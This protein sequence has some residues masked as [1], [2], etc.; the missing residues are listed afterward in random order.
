MAMIENSA[1]KELKQKKGF[2]VPDGAAFV[3]TIDVNLDKIRDY[4]VQSPEQITIFNG[5][6]NLV[7]YN[8]QLDNISDESFLI[9]QSTSK[10]TR[11][12]LMKDL[13]GNGII[14]IPI[15][16]SNVTGGEY[17]KFV[18]PK[19]NEKLLDTR[20]APNFDNLFIYDVDGNDTL[21]VIIERLDSV[22]IFSSTVVIP[23]SINY[24]SI[25]SILATLESYPNPTSQNCTIIWKQLGSKDGESALVV[26][27]DMQGHE[28][29][30]IS[31]AIRE[32]KATFEWDGKGK[33]SNYVPSGLYFVK[34]SSGEQT[35]GAEIVV[36][37]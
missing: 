14:D 16:G 4:I 18:D 36:T 17:L 2:K 23:N 29:K 13:N 25:P 3:T 11:P 12:D 35:K 33:D 27:I 31:T 19:S 20:F 7:L 8:V 21:D 34:A 37:R 24:T 9:D 6:D 1:S 10:F 22:L 5:K 28:I 15:R 26:I 30:R 32:N